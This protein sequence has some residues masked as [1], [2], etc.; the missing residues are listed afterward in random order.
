MKFIFVCLASLSMT[1]SGLIHV[2]ANGIVLFF[3][4]LN[5]IPLLLLY[6]HLLYPFL[7]LWKWRLHVLAVV[8]SVN[9]GVH[10]SFLNR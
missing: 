9:I 8:S 7:C 2:A 5:S 6:P 3:L 1:V 10:V 4:W